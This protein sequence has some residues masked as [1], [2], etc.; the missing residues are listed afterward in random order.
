[1][2]QVH[3]TCPL[4]SQ[5]IE[6]GAFTGFTGLDLP[7]VLAV[8]LFSTTTYRFAIDLITATITTHFGYRS[9][10]HVEGEVEGRKL[11]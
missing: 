6:G 7:W 11:V 3:C 5:Y 8:L 1:M 2:Y 9:I 4:I 10:K